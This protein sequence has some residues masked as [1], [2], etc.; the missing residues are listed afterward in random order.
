MAKPKPLPRDVARILQKFRNF[1]LGRQHHSPLRFVDDISKRSQPP[2]ILPLGPS[3]KLHSNYYSD[4]DIR[5]EISHPMEL[6]GPETERLRLLKAADRWHRC[7]V[8]DKGAALRLVPGKV[9]LW[10]KIDH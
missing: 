8:K 2:P 1:L 7:E 9:H 4:R 6:F 5:G 3:N 10:D